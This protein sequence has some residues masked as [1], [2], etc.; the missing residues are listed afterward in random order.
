MKTRILDQ[1]SA[2]YRV[3]STSPVTTIIP[4]IHSFDVELF[5]EFP[6]GLLPHVVIS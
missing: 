2:A 3:S 5:A 4:I 1:Q 6:H